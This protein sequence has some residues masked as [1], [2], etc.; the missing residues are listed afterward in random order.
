MKLLKKM[1]SNFYNLGRRMNFDSL[2]HKYK[3]EEICQRDLRNYQNPIRLFKDLRDDK[4][5]TKKVLKNQINFKSDLNEIRKE[6]PDLKS[7]V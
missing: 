6:N 5:N 7:E 2:M 4:V 1:S 3:T